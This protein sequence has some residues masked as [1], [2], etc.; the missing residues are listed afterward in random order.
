M[1]RPYVQGE[2]DVPA[3]FQGEVSHDEAVDELGNTRPGYGRFLRYRHDGD[4]F[5]DNHTVYYRLP[6]R[7]EECR[8]IEGDEPMTVFESVMNPVMESG[9]MPVIHKSAL[10]VYE[11]E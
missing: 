5:V 7:C 4:K 6:A 11:V 2:G 9:G 3:P 10:P 1:K 8:T